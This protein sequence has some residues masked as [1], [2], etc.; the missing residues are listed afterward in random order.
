MRFHDV[1]WK[2]NAFL[3]LA[4]S[5]SHHSRC[6]TPGTFPRNWCSLSLG[7]LCWAL[8]KG[9]KKTN[10][11]TVCIYKLMTNQRRF[12]WYSSLV[13][14]G[15]GGEGEICL[16]QKSGFILKVEFICCFGQLLLN[17]FPKRVIHQFSWL[18]CVCHMALA[19]C[20][21]TS[22]FVIL[23]FDADMSPFCVKQKL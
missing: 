13:S 16:K 21:L 10:R 4:Y 9:L 1:S 15:F 22:S 3:F 12:H 19:K 18:S 14:E 8:L 11:P 7:R 5:R 17:I 2:V 23:W 20:I 6:D